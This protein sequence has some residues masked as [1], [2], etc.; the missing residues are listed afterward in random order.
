MGLKES[1]SLSTKACIQKF[2]SLVFICFH[3]VTLYPVVLG[4]PRWPGNESYKDEGDEP[5]DDEDG[6][7]EP[8]PKA[9]AKAKR[10]PKAKGK[11]KAKAKRTPRAPSSAGSRKMKQAEKDSSTYAKIGGFPVTCP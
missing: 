7:D 6:E 2:I 10:K 3:Y 1:W 8:E 9:K 11:A 5:E 4:M